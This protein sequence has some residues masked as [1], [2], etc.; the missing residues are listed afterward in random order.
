MRLSRL[1]LLNSNHY[2]SELIAQIASAPLNLQPSL[3]FLRQTILQTQAWTIW[4]HHKDD[5]TDQLETDIANSPLAELT[6]RRPTVGP[7]DLT[8]SRRMITTDP[9]IDLT[10]DTN[11]FCFWKRKKLY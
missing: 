1:L 5:E 3:A 4:N 6:S 11:L 9:V 8:G 2:L 10:H 7:I